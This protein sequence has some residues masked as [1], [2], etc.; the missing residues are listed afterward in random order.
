MRALMHNFSINKKKK[1]KKKVR[2]A[3]ILA[4]FPHKS[5]LFV[6]DLRDCGKLK[7]PRRNMWNLLRAQTSTVSRSHSGSDR[8]RAWQ[9]R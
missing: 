4:R 9:S 3:G 2:T 5:R 8:A 7:D 6:R 1:L